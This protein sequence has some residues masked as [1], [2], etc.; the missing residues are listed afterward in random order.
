MSNSVSEL[1]KNASDV[2]AI[3]T[4]KMS[5]ETMPFNGPEFYAGLDEKFGNFSGH[6]LIASHCFNAAWPTWE[7]HPN[8][9]E[10]V[11][12]LEG[13]ATL[14]LRKKGNDEAVHLDTS[15]QY[16]VV[17]CGVWH[18]ASAA[19]DARM[20]FITSGEGTQNLEQP[21]EG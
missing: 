10:L 12:L 21:P 19:Q 6:V 4:P 20:L 13:S 2:F 7:C 1:V 5:I 17:P 16:I 11:M 9:D 18:T 3:M 14:M 15:G 8:G